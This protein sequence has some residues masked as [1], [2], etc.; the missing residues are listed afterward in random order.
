MGQSHEAKAIS[1][2]NVSS[3]NDEPGEP[4]ENRLGFFIFSPI[5]VSWSQHSQL[6][7]ALLFLQCIEDLQH[8][9]LIEDDEFDMFVD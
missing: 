1:S 8:R 6:W 3:L 4:A 5:S 9:E 2:S 7:N